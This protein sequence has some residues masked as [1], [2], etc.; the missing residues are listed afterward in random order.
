MPTEKTQ[1]KIFDNQPIVKLLD[2]LGNFPDNLSGYSEEFE[3]KIC[4]LYQEAGSLYDGLS[5]GEDP[6]T[7]QVK[8]FILDK[9]L[10]LILKDK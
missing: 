6:T 9:L 7:E 2:L 5:A 10:P 3:E 4:N 8:Q 1:K